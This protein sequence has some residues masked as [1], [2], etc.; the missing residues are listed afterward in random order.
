[1][2]IYCW[3]VLLM[4]YYMNLVTYFVSVCEVDEMGR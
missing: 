1:M 3:L 2:N 4:P